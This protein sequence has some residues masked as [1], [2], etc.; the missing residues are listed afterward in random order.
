MTRY[1]ILAAFVA[2]FVAAFVATPA[3]HAA[4]KTN[5]PD[6]VHK[7]EKAEWV[8]RCD[9]LKEAERLACLDEVRIEAQQRFLDPK[10]APEA[11]PEKNT[12]TKRP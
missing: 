3:I 4:E 12:D 2:I 8:K 6:R 10:S 11:A 5:K 7:P 1:R 9:R